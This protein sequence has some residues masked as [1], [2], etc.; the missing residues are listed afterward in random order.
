[1]LY[2]NLQEL[3][4]REES[5]KASIVSLNLNPVRPGRPDGLNL[6]LHL[7]PN[8]NLNLNL[9]FNLHLHLHLHLNLFLLNLPP[10]NI[11]PSI[12]VFNLH[13]YLHFN[14]DEHNFHNISSLP[15]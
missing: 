12:Y 2:R 7:H 14:N 4:F 5:A 1:M 8:L 6:N 11:S 13:L 10:K 15:L 3:N 9:H